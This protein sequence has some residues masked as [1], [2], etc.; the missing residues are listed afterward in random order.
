MAGV[1]FISKILALA[2]MTFRKNSSNRQASL[3]ISPAQANS[4][5]ISLNLPAVS[6]NLIVASEAVLQTEKGVANGVATLG[7]DGLV[8]YSQLPEIPGISAPID[9]Q[10]SVIN[11]QT[12]GTVFRLPSSA[13]KGFI[14]QVSVFIEGSSS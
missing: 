6:G 3:D 1:P 14:A 8:P 4:T 9:F 10:G 13:Y 7:S 11:D 5:N 12:S 2:G